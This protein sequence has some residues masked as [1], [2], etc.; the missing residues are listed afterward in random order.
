[1]R[2]SLDR[3]T[4]NGFL[5]RLVVGSSRRVWY[6]P[7][8]RSNRETVERVRQGDPSAISEL[9]VP[10]ADSVAVYRPNVYAL[11][12]RHLGPLTPL[13]AEQLRLAERAYPRAWIEEAIQQAV[14][15]NR[16]NWRYV[17]SI[18][19]RWEETGAPDVLSGKGS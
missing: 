19:R 2:R 12:E 15:Y 11:Y 10:D 5:Y 3:A 7:A 13:V 18:L 14:Q 4:A 6:V 16:R 9:G 1:M 17:E 8:T